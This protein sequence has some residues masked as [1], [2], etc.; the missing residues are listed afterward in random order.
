[1]PG[2]YPIRIEAKDTY[3]FSVSGVRIVRIEDPDT[4]FDCRKRR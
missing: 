3:G 2:I 4:P 1:M